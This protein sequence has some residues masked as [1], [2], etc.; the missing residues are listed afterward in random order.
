MARSATWQDLLSQWGR[1][2]TVI[3]REAGLRFPIRPDN[4]QL[5]WG[6]PDPATFPTA[7]LVRAFGAAL[8]READ[9]ALQY[10]GGPAVGRFKAF[11]AGVGARRGLPDDP[12]GVLVTAGS[13]Q[14]LDLIFRTFLDP[15]DAVVVESPTYLGA[16]R[17]VQNHRAVA[18]G[19]PMDDA[20]L[21]VDL[22]ADLL[23]RRRRAGEPLPKLA[24]VIPSFHN[25]AGVTLPLE[26]RQRLL[27]LAEEFGFYL[28]EDDA[29]GE[30]YFGDAAPAPL[31]A[32]ARSDAS[33]AAPSRVIYLNTLSKTIAPGVRIGWITGEPE[34]VATIA[35]LKVDGGTNPL[36]QTVLEEFCRSGAY[37][38][39][40]EGLRRLYAGRKAAMLAALEVHMPP[41]VRWTD[42]SG[43]FFVWLRLPE[44]MA[45]SALAPVAAAEG[46][47]YVE[48]HP[49]FVPG[50][51]D[52]DRHLRLCF[53]ALP[54]DQLAEGIRRLATAIARLRRQ[55]G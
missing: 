40:L 47:T 36:V 45:S 12:A 6:F 28:V 31:A 52:A 9:E 51:P 11:L 17:V 44:G 35:R 8:D 34:L 3:G 42:P 32:L 26:R 4:I 48:G 18:L 54:E 30:L 2:G 21:R 14:A 29:Y 15:G 53:S 23:A 22:V 49:F 25:P 10:G 37:L 33:P 24:Y 1:A 41:D 27:A 19:V 7:G 13:S 55:A 46:V 38:E 5:S 16:L 43:G 50:T 39:R 20:G